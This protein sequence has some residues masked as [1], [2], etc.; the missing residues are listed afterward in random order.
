MTLTQILAACY[1]ELRYSA[2]PPSAT[3]TRLTSFVNSTYRDVLATPGLER[4]RDSVTPVTALSGVARTGLPPI[5]SRVL[6]VV[7]R[8]NNHKLWQVPL[9]ELR[10]DDPAQAF[11]GGYPLRYAVIGEQAV[12]RQPGTTG[13]V[14]A[15]TAAGDT[16][17][18]VFVE[19]YLTGGYPNLEITA[20]TTLTGTA[21]VQVGTRTDHIEVTKF[22]LD[23]ATVGFVSLYD[24]AASGNE[25]V[26]LAI[27]QTY[28]RTLALEWWPIP[29]QDT[30]EYMDY[31]RVVQD[32][33]K[34]TDEPMFP[35]DFHDTIVDGTKSR[36]YSYLDDAVRESRTKIDY[37]N[38]IKAM[39][40]WVMNDGDRIASFR[41]QAPR[42]SSLG[43]TYPS[44][45]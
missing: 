35:A 9:G 14:A 42:W 15:S 4:L 31:T 16:T 33:V 24:A 7:D 39:T 21:R 18:K 40:A 30:T 32:L 17:Q 44:G 6:K 38:G 19:S 45:T 28:A 10:R 1:S 22:Y 3:V 20:G 25:L 36:E 23:L 41:K 37:L 13:L 27:G 34:G 26:R 43:P 11:T 8:T 5:V 2:S 12:V 29:M